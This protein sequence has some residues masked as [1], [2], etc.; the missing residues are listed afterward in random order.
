VV[1]RVFV[2]VHV[3][4]TGVCSFTHPASRTHNVLFLPALYGSMVV[5]PL[6]QWLST[7]LRLR[8]F[9]T[10]PHSVVTPDHKSI[11]IA[12]SQL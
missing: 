5:L 10:I 2:S 9:D 11:F 1:I 8:P 4:G 6:E 3:Y 12:T 7:F